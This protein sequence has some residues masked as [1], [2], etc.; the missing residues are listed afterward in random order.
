VIASDRSG[1][2]GFA[3]YVV[4]PYTWSEQATCHLEDL[5]VRPDARRRGVGRSLIEHV[6][7]LGKTEGWARVYWMTEAGNQ[8]AR[9]L[10]DTFCQ[11]DGFVRYTVSLTEPP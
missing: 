2:L 3:S 11:A 8:R 5:F 4:H 9:S 7:D 1:A 10:Y 6:V